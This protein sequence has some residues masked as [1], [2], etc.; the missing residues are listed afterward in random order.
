MAIGRKDLEPSRAP[1]TL[2][3][4]G[5]ALVWTLD[6]YGE[7]GLRLG[8]LVIQTTGDP[9]TGRLIAQTVRLN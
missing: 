2:T 1:Y 9:A 8:T 7:Y 4:I 5:K 3:G 6:V